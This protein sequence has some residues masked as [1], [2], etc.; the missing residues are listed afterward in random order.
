MHSQIGLPAAP[1]SPVQAV[2]EP[3]RTNLLNIRGSCYAK[4]QLCRLGGPF[5]SSVFADAGGNLR[6]SEAVRRENNHAFSI[7]QASSARL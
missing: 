1:S 7:R 6:Q 4:A 3:E 2:N 5:R